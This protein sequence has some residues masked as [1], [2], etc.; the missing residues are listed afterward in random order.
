MLVAFPLYLSSCS[1]KLTEEKHGVD[2]PLEQSGP[3]NPAKQWQDPE[4]HSPLP[5]Q[6]R[7]HSTT[8]STGKKK[9]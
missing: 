6:F 3:R 7:G 9:G 8:D 5:W 1:L 2:L 4:T